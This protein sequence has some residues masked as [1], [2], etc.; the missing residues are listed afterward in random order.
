M[1]TEDLTEFIDADDFAD[2]ATYDG[3]TTVYGIFDGVYV[4]AFGVAGSN[5]V[6]LCA[7]SDVPAAGVCKT[8]VVNSV[9]YKIRNRQPQDDGAFVLLQLEKQ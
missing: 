5:P 6:F 8:L 2:A 4:D 7:A 9:T 1:F 3:S